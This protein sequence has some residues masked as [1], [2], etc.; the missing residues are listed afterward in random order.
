MADHPLK[1]ATHRSLGEPLPH[2][3]ANGSQ[4]D[5]SVAEAFHLSILVGISTGF[6]VLSRAKGYVTYVLLTRSPLFRRSVRLACVKPAAS[7]RSE[8][9][10]N[11]PV[12]ILI[13]STESN[14]SCYLLFKD[15]TLKI[16]PVAPLASSQ[17]GHV[18][19]GMNPPPLLR[20]PAL[21]AN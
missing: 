18:A 11:S 13:N 16:E 6:P 12:C 20:N 17:F 9:G 3:L 8:P 1:P 10:S 21:L 2:Q 15:R 14:R 7:V 19:R 5:P 4:A